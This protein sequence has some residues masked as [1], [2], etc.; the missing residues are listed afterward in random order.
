MIDPRLRKPMLAILVLP[1]VILA[2]ALFT[3]RDVS[4]TS[5]AEGTKPP[6]TRTEADKP[7][8]DHTKFDVLKQTFAT[9][10]DVTKACLSCHTEAADQ[11]H[12]TTH[13][14]WEYTDPATGKLEGK[15]NVINNFCVSL[16]TNEARCTSCHIGYGWKDNT[17]NFAAKENVDCLV[18][19]DTTATYKKLPNGAGH[20]AYKDTEFPVGSGTIWKPLDLSKIAQNVG[21]TSRTTCGTCHFSGGG[22]DS[23]KH[24]DLDPSLRQ[25]D[26]SIDVH[27]DAKGLNF[28]CATCHDPTNHNIPGSRYNMT[29]KDTHGVDTPGNSDGN[30]ATCESCHGLAPHNLDL[31][32]N[33]H[34]N[35]VACETCHIPTVAKNYATKVWWD[36]SKAG[37]KDASGKTFITKGDMGEP[38]YDSQKGEFRWEKNYSPELIWFN[39]KTNWMTVQDSSFPADTAIVKVNDF[40]GSYA[41]TNS[42][43]WPVKRFEGVQPYDTTN[44][45]LV[46]PHLFGADDNAYWKSYDWS[47]A[48]TAGAKAVGQNYSGAYGFIRTQATWPQTHMVAPAEKALSCEECHTKSADGRLANLKDFYLP[49]RDSTPAV[50]NF[51]LIAIIGTVLG[52]GGH[53]ISH[54]TRKNKK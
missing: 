52:I 28:T 49:G 13:W 8:A 11:L 10:P 18:C 46:A 9:G 17:F 32:I 45:F 47:K 14:T 24:G 51:G 1:L 29:A 34:V 37:V 20:P 50:E 30:R 16:S 4:A 44:N 39:G 2:I 26:A 53:G 15:K 21:K 23:V 27:M 7:T 40:K 43:I 48:L 19:H 6:V 36:W 38:I 22:G 35:K 41:D 3:A 12:K 31:Q 5:T 33:G 54:L 42:R 25:P